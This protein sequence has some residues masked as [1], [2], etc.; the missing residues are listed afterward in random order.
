LV[1]T[2][3]TQSRRQEHDKDKA[4]GRR[5]WAVRRRALDKHPSESVVVVVRVERKAAAITQLST[6]NIYRKWLARCK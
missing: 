6:L 3:Q 2:A 1:G 4:Q 5:G